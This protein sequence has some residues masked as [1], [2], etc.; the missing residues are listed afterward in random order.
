MRLKKESRVIGFDD[1]PFSKNQQKTL[2]VGII[3]RGGECFDGMI[4]SEISVDGLDATEIISNVINKSK[5]KKELRVVMF[6]G[7]TI[8]GFNLIDVEGLN[9][10]T[11]LPVIIIS[12]KKPDMEKIRKA[13]ENFKDWKYRWSIIKK[14]GRINKLKLK[15]NKNIYFQFYGLSKN[16][17]EQ[18]ILLTC[19]RSL[20][21]EPLRLAHMIASAFVRGE[22]GGRA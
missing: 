4:K 14:A 2:V 8:G 5:Y 13:L 20:I 3:T 11:G 21:P 10:K 16:D 18:I 9:K 22:C 6:K 7:L 17:A 12:R 1:G 15:N 19:M